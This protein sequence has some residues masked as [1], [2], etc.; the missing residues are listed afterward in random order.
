[1]EHEPLWVKDG[2]I[3]TGAGI[4]AGIDLALAW[5][6]EDCGAALAHEAA[7]EA[8]ALSAPPPARALRRAA[9]QMVHQGIGWIVTFAGTLPVDVRSFAAIALCIF[10]RIIHRA[11]DIGPPCAARAGWDCPRRGPG[12]VCERYFGKRRGAGA[13][14]RGG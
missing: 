6:E 13:C 4:S 1:V 14:R 9:G 11:S 8:R 5:V 12:S 2:N 10:A 7:R 3:Y